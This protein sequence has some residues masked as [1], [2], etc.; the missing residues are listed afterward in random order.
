MGPPLQA[1]CLFPGEDPR[2]RK[3]AQQ[4]AIYSAG[5]QAAVL[6]AKGRGLLPAGPNPDAGYSEPYGQGCDVHWSHELERRFG[7][8]LENRAKAPALEISE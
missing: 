7:A 6:E 8:G 1:Q 2:T 4:P 5:G 3:E